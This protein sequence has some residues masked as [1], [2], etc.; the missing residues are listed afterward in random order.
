MPLTA[1][2]PVAWALSAAAGPSSGGD[3]GAGAAAGD[4]G[5]GAGAGAGTGAGAGA[6]AEDADNA[7]TW[8]CIYGEKRV[9]DYSTDANAVRATVD[10]TVAEHEREKVCWWG[11]W[12]LNVWSRLTRVFLCFAGFAA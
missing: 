3:G 7:E 9:G 11:W 8:K 2:D 10:A 12:G 1:Y 6:D 4:G 5:A